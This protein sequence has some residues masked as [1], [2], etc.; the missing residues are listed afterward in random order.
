M[1]VIRLASAGIITVSLQTPRTAKVSP[2]LAVAIAAAIVSPA[3]QST[4]RVLWAKPPSTAASA[5]EIERA[6]LRR[7][8][9]SI[10]SRFFRCVSSI[11]NALPTVIEFD[12]VIRA[13]H[14]TRVAQLLEFPTDV[15]IPAAAEKCDSSVPELS[16]QRVAPRSKRWRKMNSAASVPSVV[17]APAHRHPDHEITRSTDHEMKRQKIV[18]IDCCANSINRVGRTPR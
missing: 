7:R 18:P 12:P 13:R 6:Q 3:E 11:T 15:P 1:S 9:R 5:I 14:E 16:G 4:G 17:D 10:Q 2:G 8:S